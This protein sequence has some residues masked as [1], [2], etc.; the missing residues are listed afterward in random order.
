[1]LLFKL[2]SCQSGVQFSADLHGSSALVPP[3]CCLRKKKKKKACGWH[4]LKLKSRSSDVSRS[5]SPTGSTAEGPH[6]PALLSGCQQ[7]AKA[8]HRWAGEQEQVRDDRLSETH[9]SVLF[10]SYLHLGN[11][12]DMP[13]SMRKLLYYCLSQS[14]K[15]IFLFLIICQPEVDL[16]HFRHLPQGLWI[17]TN[18]QDQKFTDQA[19]I[20]TVPYIVFDW[21][22]YVC[23]YRSDP[24]EIFIFIL[25]YYTFIWNKRSESRMHDK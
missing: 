24:I 9:A 4:Q 7:T 21:L 8:A 10:C 12:I 5:T 16:H 14:L 19:P 1:M 17:I 11:L 6:G 22:L 25:I 18:N 15:L 2:F 20:P 3:V 23:L 13:V